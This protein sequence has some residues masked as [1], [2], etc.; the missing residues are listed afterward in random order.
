MFL[1][2]DSRK[3][4]EKRALLGTILQKL[5]TLQGLGHISEDNSIIKSTEQY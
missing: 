2:E 5:K 3:T 1:M 4:Y